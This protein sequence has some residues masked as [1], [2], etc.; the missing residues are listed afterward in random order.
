[1]DHEEPTP[2]LAIP[3]DG[4]PGAEGQVEPVS[5]LTMVSPSLP[6]AH[7]LNTA[8]DAKAA[9]DRL[10]R[11]ARFE[12]LAFNRPPYSVG[13]VNR[14]VLDAL[15]RGVTIRSLYQPAVEGP[16]AEE[17]RQVMEAYDEAGVQ[18]RVV[19]DLPVQMAIVDRSSTLLAL[20][21]P[22]LAPGAFRTVV[23]V[24]HNG[25]SAVQAYAFEQLWTAAR[26]YRR[27]RRAA[28]AVGAQQQGG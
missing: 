26:P 23:L 20:S 21:D 11:D 14:S 4:A 10:L 6:F 15:A 24:E 28:A 3:Q 19:V 16:E 9:Y 13:P 7:L 1:M 12:V 8:A 22:L 2:L 17:F 5:A 25:F 18:C 27:R